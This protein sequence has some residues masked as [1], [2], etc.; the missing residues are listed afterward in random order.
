MKLFKST[1][2]DFLG[3]KWLFISLSLVLT[4]VSLMSLV[5]KDGPLYGIDFR[6]GAL[7]YVKFAKHPPAH[8]I[9]T[10]LASKLGGAI[11]VTELTNS[12]EVSRA[13]AVA[14]GSERVMICLSRPSW[15]A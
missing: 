7:M 12:S 5:V 4:V 9:R 2:F 14:R 1:N 10:A 15:R 13:G 6:G 11:S 8:Q 3:R